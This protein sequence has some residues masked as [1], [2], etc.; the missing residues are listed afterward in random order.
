MPGIHISAH[1]IVREVI[2]VVEAG[3]FGLGVSFIYPVEVVVVWG[4]PFVVVFDEV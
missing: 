3:A 2:E 1:D 4:A